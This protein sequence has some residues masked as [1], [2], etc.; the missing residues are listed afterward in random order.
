[1][2]IYDYKCE[3]CG[4]S[5]ER[6]V[7]RQDFSKPQT[8]DCGESA[9]REIGDV[10]FVLKGDGWFGKNLKLRRQMAAKNRRLDEKGRERRHDAGV[11]LVPNVNGERVDS[12]E[13]ARQL[14]AAGG[15]STEGYD[16]KIREEK[17]DP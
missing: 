5:F 13:E 14:A 16:A 17:V 6:S 8:C 7:S 10:G 12:W 11:R 3:V 1:M 9:P 15:L 4:A 2:P